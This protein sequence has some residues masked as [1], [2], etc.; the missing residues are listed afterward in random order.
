MYDRKLYMR[1]YRSLAKYEKDED[2]NIAWLKEKMIKNGMNVNKDI[3][4]NEMRYLGKNERSRSSSKSAKE[5]YQVVKN[6]SCIFETKKYSRC[7]KKIFK[8]ID[9]ENFLKN[10]RTISNKLYNKI[11]RK[12]YGLRLFLPL[13][14]LLLLS[15]SLLLD[16]MG[17]GLIKMLSKYEK[18]E[19][20]NIAWLKEKMIKNGMNVNKDICYNEMRYLGKNERSRSSSKSAKENYQ[21]VKNNSCI[22]ETKKYSRCEKK[23]FKEIDFENFLKNNRTI[24][25]KLY[26]KIIRKKYGLRLFLPLLFLLLLSTSLLLDFMGLGLIKML[27]YIFKIIKPGSL[28]YLHN[29]LK[30]SSFNMFFKSVAKPELTKTVNTKVI[31]ADHYYVTGFFGIFIYLLPFILFG[32]TLILKVVYYHKKVKKYQKIKYRKR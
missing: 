13:L 14:F 25:N 12:K 9:F 27:C 16:F 23:I 5:N 28:N 22:F 7:E 19:D 17:L 2:S 1:N 32:V 4:Y 24:S 11:I 20:S 3:C 31:K 18:D 10:N 8:E 26:N 21:V 29:M 6:N 30:G 15:T